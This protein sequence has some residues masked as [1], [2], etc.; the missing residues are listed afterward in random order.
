MLDVLHWRA[1]P[2]SAQARAELDELRSDALRLFLVLASAGYLGWHLLTTTLWPIERSALAYMIA[3]VAVPALAGAFFILPHSHRAATALFIAGQFLAISWALYVSE[4][5]QAAF[6]FTVLALVAAFVVHP[7]MGF[8]VVGAA[9]ATL[10]L[11]AAARPGAIGP[12]AAWQTLIL[13]SVS[14]VGVWALMRHLSLA[15]SW[16]VDSYDQAK[17]RM[18]EAQEDRAQLVQALK[19]LDIAYYRLERANAALAM[20]WKAADEAERS[21]SELVVNISHELRTPLNLIAG[22]SELLVTD[23][24]SYGGEPLPAVY[25]GDANAI[26][27]SAQH[28]LALMDDILDLAQAGVQK[29][30]LTIEPTDL[31]SVVHEATDLVRDYIA[32]KGLALTTE[33]PDGPVVVP[34]D[35]LRVRQ[36]LL[37]L[38]TNAVRFTGV[39]AIA[40][41]LA[42]READV[43]L[44]VADTGRGMPPEVAGRVFEEYY[45]RDQPPP[46]RSGWHAGAGL[47][48]PISKKLVELHG[49]QM[50]VE[51]AEGFGT[52]FSFTLPLR[53]PP[54]DAAARTMRSRAIPPRTVARGAAADPVVVLAGGDPAIGRLMRRH[55]T[56]YRVIAAR[57][58]AEAACQAAELRASAIVADS[59]QP[60]DQ[61]ATL[62]PIVRLPFPHGG[63]IA[64]APGVVDC[65]VMPI[66]RAQL[67]AAI[68]R[69]GPSVRRVLI[70]AAD[71]R[72]VRLLTRM[73]QLGER[74]YS[75]VAAH[76][77]Q[78]ALRSMR[79][80]RPD[81]VLLGPALPDLDSQQVVQAMA[82]DADLAAIPVVVIS[83][84]DQAEGELMVRGDIVVTKPEGYRLAEV[85]GALQAAL[86]FLSPPRAYL[87]A[88]VG[89]PA[90]GS[91]A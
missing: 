11:L 71:P 31:V 58:P 26:F 64:Q 9:V 55:L 67:L 13:G 25:R 10:A 59:G 80:N 24:E 62:T 51:S 81:L 12:D 40:V 89:A 63:G 34:C 19:Q 15:L 57:G 4:A 88:R 5:P 29:L 37:N 33:A 17:R 54:A 53:Q 22:F 83:A 14:V 79:S 78:E 16:Y 36:V 47:G 41:E 49:G 69:A 39:G 7:L 27:R 1:T 66:A 74:R 20:A 56:G 3:L 48:L 43:L 87:G 73:V 21:R 82:E 60:F 75:V 68:A 46:E 30:P 72:A 91:D 18:R 8:S 42:V 28:L 77:G 45:R 76:D 6:L 32:A 84:G 2:G 70:A 61:V 65:L 23:A 44:A 52:R 35:R 38:L 90:T 50:R 86:S 85:V